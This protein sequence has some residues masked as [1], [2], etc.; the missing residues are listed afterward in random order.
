MSFL[1]EDKGLLREL[2]KLSQTTPAPAAPAAPAPEATKSI[3]LAK[4]LIQ[5]L[6]KELSGGFNFT[7]ERDNA[8]LSQAHVVSVDD[9][10]YFLEFN[11]IKANGKSLVLNARQ[12]KDATTG[13]MTNLVQQMGE[14]GKDYVQWPIQGNPQYYLYKDGMLAFLKDLEEKAANNPMLKAI[15][16][17]LKGLLSAALPQKVAPPTDVAGD[18]TT[19]QVNPQPANSNSGAAQTGGLTPAIMQ[20][21][22]ADLPF[23]NRAIDF[24]RI[25]RFFDAVNP[26][27][28][29]LPEVS[30]NIQAVKQLITDINSNHMQVQ[31]TVFPLGQAPRQIANMFKGKETRE[32]GRNFMPVIAKLSDILDKTRQVL[33]VFYSRYATNPVFN[34]TYKAYVLGQI[35]RTPDDASI[36]SRNSDELE[37]L[38][39]S[40]TPR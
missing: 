38:R 40:V 22:I 19:P 14:A 12:W 9:L 2:L 4:Q 21:I 10:L 3:E 1:H 26:V 27:I 32:E 34:D 39:R 31:T 35:G 24:S 18:S 13:K 30:G 28:G 37:N 36:Y 11:G 6:Y 29:R 33:E 23:V 17:K 7:A 15:V 8:D 5:N 20:Q 25:N 16:A